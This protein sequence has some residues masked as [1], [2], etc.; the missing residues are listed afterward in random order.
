M[1]IAKTIYLDDDFYKTLQTLRE[2]DVSFNAYVNRIL[3]SYALH[4][5]NYL[6]DDDI[7]SI[8]ISFIR[9]NITE[10]R[11]FLISY[12]DKERS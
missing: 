7:I 3:L 4:H 9:D 6:S 5:F 11:Q 1:A 8:L 10:F 2:G 12:L